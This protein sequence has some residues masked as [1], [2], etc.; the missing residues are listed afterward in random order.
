MGLIK[1]LE[2]IALY[3]HIVLIIGERALAVM[4]LVILA[5]S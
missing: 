2:G 1:F 5:R 4:N 3:I